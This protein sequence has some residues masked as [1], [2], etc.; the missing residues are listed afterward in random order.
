MAT[1]LKELL[2]S[3]GGSVVAVGLAVSL[4]LL[5]WFVPRECARPCPNCPWA[6]NELRRRRFWQLRIWTE[7]L[8]VTLSLLIVTYGLGRAVC[9]LLLEEVAW[10]WPLLLACGAWGVRLTL[11]GLRELDQVKEKSDGG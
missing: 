4:L 5:R 1:A 10:T 2:N 7:R 9:D 11:L 8:E 6:N 3:D